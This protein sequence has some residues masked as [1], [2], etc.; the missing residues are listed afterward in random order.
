MVPWQSFGGWKSGPVSGA[1]HS[2]V[3]MLLVMIMV[4]SI[5]P[6][7]GAELDSSTK[8]ASRHTGEG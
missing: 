1:T 5:D 6:H 3:E 4:G 2:S 8:A 7:E